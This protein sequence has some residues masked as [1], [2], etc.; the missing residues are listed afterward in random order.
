MPS[1]TLNTADQK[2]LWQIVH[3]IV[4]VDGGH[5]A[6]VEVGVHAGATS[7]FLL[8][9]FPGL[10]LHMIDPWC[11]YAPNHPYRK[12]GDS[13][14]KMSLADQEVIMR[15]AF[16]RTEKYSTRRTIHRDTSCNVAATFTPA[17]VDFVFID[18]DHTLE[19]VWSDLEM[20]HPKLKPGGLLCGHDYGHPR[21]VRGIWGVK[22]SVDRFAAKHGLSV[23]C[24]SSRVWWLEQP[25]DTH[26]LLGLG[27]V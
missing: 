10:H 13:C 8:A 16:E 17:S 20:W 18:G 12:S 21:D 26:R 24:T 5:F 7:E 19:A 14:A 1:R 9:E 27:A 6:G 3:G 15:R 25:L 23:A 11:I 4:P 2:D 22:A